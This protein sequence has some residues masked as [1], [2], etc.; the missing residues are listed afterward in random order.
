MRKGGKEKRGW[1]GKQKGRGGRAGQEEGNGENG[2]KEKGEGMKRGQG[3]VFAWVKIKS[4][5]R[6]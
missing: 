6:P 4:W 2:K 5:I 3:K 1:K